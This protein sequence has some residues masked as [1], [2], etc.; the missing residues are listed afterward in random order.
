MIDKLMQGEAIEVLPAAHFFMGGVKINERCET[1]VPGLYAA[2]E[3][4]GGIHGA[5]RLSG[6]AFSH[7][8]V[9]GRRAGYFAAQ[10]A[11]S[12]SAPPEPGMEELTVFEKKLLHPIQVQ[13]NVNPYEVKRELQDIAWHKLGVIRDSTLLNSALENLDE[14]KNTKLALMTSRARQEHFNLEWLEC[15]Q[16]ENIVLVQ[17]AIAR[18]ALLR[19][20]SRGAHFRK[21]YPDMDNLN[22]LRSTLTMMTDEGI[23]VTTKPVELPI[24]N[25][26]THG[27]SRNNE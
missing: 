22:W 14:I 7:M 15:L 1:T 3:T 19:S 16:V 13:G 9:M 4:A 26:E 12:Q 18:C 10:H 21:D 11:A 17:E 24:V 6:T 20:E 8:L 25:P 23:A 27:K 5:N 2:G